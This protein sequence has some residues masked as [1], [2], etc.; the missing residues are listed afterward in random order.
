MFDP[1][2]YYKEILS[3]NVN[4][5]I[6]NLT[7]NIYQSIDEVVE[8]IL[9]NNQK[10]FVDA[11]IIKNRE[12]LSRECHKFHAQ[13]DTLSEGVEQS[14]MNL[15]DPDVI[16]IEA[17]H[18]PNFLPYVGYIQK[19]ILMN[20]I[21]DILSE[22][23]YKV[24]TLFGFL[25]SSQMRHRWARSTAL[26]DFSRKEK[27]LF[28]R[29]PSKNKATTFSHNP[30]PDNTIVDKWERELIV[31]IK[32]NRKII[33]KLSRKYEGS[34]AIDFNK[35]KFYLENLDIIFNQIRKSSDKSKNFGDFNS[36]I[37][38]KIINGNFDKGTLFY[39]YSDTI[40][41]FKNKF[42][43]IVTEHDLFVESYNRNFE[44]LISEIKISKED[45][46]KKIGQDYVPFRY[47]CNCGF[48]VSLELSQN[49]F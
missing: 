12:R 39:N 19:I 6:E 31:W 26:M 11:E 24:V 30:V 22:K 40:H 48:P 27:K 42:K 46:F 45:N 41:L 29:V 14:L 37:L 25:D 10:E 20:I 2:T 34:P 1:Q 7:G 36:I 8:N 28:L 43:K 23:G 18:Q 13:A 47:Q 33:N 38:S 5:Q 15:S 21:S 44:Q 16:L 17:A 35:E 4:N 9:L 49:N 3:K 32:N